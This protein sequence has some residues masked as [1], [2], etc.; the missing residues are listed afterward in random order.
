MFKSLRLLAAVALLCLYGCGE[1]TAALPPSTPSNGYAIYVT[2]EEAGTV[3]IVDGQSETCVA[4]VTVGKRPRG[5]KLS[6][7]GKTAYVTLSGSPM[8]GPGVDE[9]KLPPADK[10]ADGIGV[11]SLVDRKLVGKLPSGSDPEQFD[12]TND[13]TKL[14][15]SNEDAGTASILDIKTSTLSAPIPVGEEPEGV[16]LDRQNKFAYVTCEATHEI[17]KIDMAT[18]KVVGKLDVGARPRTIAILRDGLSAY[19]PS[20]TS[21]EVFKIKLEPMEILKTIKPEGKNIRPM[22]LLLSPDS[23]HLYVS[24]GHG[25]KVLE[26]D[27]ATDKVSREVTV[28]KRPWGLA[29]SPDGKTLFSANG[30]SNDISIVDTTTF[31]TIKQIPVG[32]KPWGV[33]VGPA[34]K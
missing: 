3:S 27:T 5:I 1:H 19:V 7:D 13:G 34:W 21:G 17:Y 22:C 29:L 31:Q 14:V 6:P 4:T 23:K 12:I 11:I 16:S 32:A 15:I 2:N 24:T 8:A 10:K 18:A 9:L 26:I 33:A 30:P 20:E 25:G 28:G